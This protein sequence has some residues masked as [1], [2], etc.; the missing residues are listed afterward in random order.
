MRCKLADKGTLFRRLARFYSGDWRNIFRWI[1]ERDLCAWD[2][3]QV[4][5]SEIF[6]QCAGMATQA[7]NFFN[8]LFHFRQFACFCGEFFVGICDSYLLKLSV[9]FACKIRRKE[10]TPME[11]K[12]NLCAMI[13]ADLHA[14]VIAEKEE[15]ELRTLAEYVEWI[16][17]E[18]FEG[19][20]AV[21][22]G[23]K[24]LAFQ[25]SEEL[26]QRLK[27]FIAAEKKRGR[28]ISQKEFV[29][30][31]IEQALAEYEAQRQTNE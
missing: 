3:A 5:H 8:G 28:K 30:G 24:T 2:N 31:L 7:I 10:Y 11:A 13:P 21:M 18:H 6:R 4:Q 16:L 23:T 27:N 14:K 9:C 25:I 29:I 19:G 22:A 26:D 20:R 1:G 15:L 12:K 17:R